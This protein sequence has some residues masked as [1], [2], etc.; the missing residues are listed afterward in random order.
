VGATAAPAA[1]TSAAPAASDSLLDPATGIVRYRGFLLMPQG[2]RGW[3]VRPERSPMTVLPFRTATL[4]LSD[5]K[6]LVDGRLRA[7]R[8]GSQP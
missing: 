3:L 7:I 8:Q 2:D 1:R 5:V 4:P 6:A